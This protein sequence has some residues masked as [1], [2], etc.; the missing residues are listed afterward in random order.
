VICVGCYLKDAAPSEYASDTSCTV[1]LP[2]FVEGHPSFGLAT[3]APNH[4]DSGA[5]PEMRGHFHHNRV[6]LT[7]HVQLE[8]GRRTLCRPSLTAGLHR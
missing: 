8:H 6:G 5:L 7:R 2:Y 1:E 3:T 4:Y